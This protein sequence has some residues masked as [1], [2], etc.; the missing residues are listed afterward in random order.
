MIPKES[1]YSVVSISIEERKYQ[2]EMMI[3]YSKTGVVPDYQTI[4]LESGS[5]LASANSFKRGNSTMKAI[6]EY[7][8]K[9]FHAN[10]KNQMPDDI[11]TLL[12]IW[13]KL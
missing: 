11:K 5:G 13:A 9:R 10:F 6:R 1:G 12:E 8:T 2:K 7:L 3:K 4:A